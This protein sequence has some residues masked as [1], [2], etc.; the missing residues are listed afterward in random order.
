[1]TAKERL[2]ECVDAFTETEA[3]KALEMLGLEQAEWPDFPP[4][5]PKVMEMFHRAMAD[6]D[7]GRTVSDEE[8]TRQFGLA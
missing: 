2:T 7:A 8:V 4:A 5:S 6:S 3:E 1:M